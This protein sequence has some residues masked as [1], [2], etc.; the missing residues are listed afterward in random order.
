[1]HNSEIVPNLPMFKSFPG[2]LYFRKIICISCK[3][4]LHLKEISAFFNFYFFH[5]FRKANI[6]MIS[7]KP[8]N[9]KRKTVRS[10]SCLY[11]AMIISILLAYSWLYLTPHILH[12]V[13]N[14]LPTVIIQ[15]K[16]NAISST[17]SCV[18]EIV[19]NVFSKIFFSKT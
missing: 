9:N 3:S 5:K 12:I 19:Q 2:S 14:H 15:Q 18:K 16:L 4:S 8:S 17:S 13:Q 6:T 10:A 7:R 1:M 11:Y